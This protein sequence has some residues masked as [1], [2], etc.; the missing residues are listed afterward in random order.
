MSWGYK[1]TILYL[2]FVGLI[3]FMVTK[4]FTHKVDLV[5]K[6]YYAKELKYQEVIDAKQNLQ[7]FGSCEIK[8]DADNIAFVLPKEFKA[9]NAVGTIY[10]HS[11]SSSDNDAR[12]ALSI[13]SLAT[14]KI[15][16]SELASGYYKV[17]VDFRAE[18]KSYF[19]E[20]NYTVTKK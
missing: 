2:A 3:V 6:D 7:A 20:Q 12:F 5:D 10:F 1:I 15:K 16:K 18:G 11:P 9:K 4:T 19:Y 13:D 14:Q 8:Q 17:E